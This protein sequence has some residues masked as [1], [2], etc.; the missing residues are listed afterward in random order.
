MDA[1]LY[2]EILNDDVLGTLRDLEINKKDIYFQQDNDTK[3]TSHLTQCY[4]LTRTVGRSSFKS[5][6][7]ESNTTVVFF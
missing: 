4:G 6:A 1:K 3:H 7:A 2:V 5:S